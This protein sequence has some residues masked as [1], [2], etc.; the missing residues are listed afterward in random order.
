MESRYMLLKIAIM[1]AAVVK[2]SDDMK[3][4]LVDMAEVQSMLTTM[5]EKLRAARTDDSG[6]NPESTSDPLSH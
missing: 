6:C 2:L 5:R 3:S 4:V 1:Q